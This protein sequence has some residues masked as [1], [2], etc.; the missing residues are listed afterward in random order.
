[1]KMS[2][3]VTIGGRRERLEWTIL[4]D[5]IVDGPGVSSAEVTLN[6]P[7]PEVVV[8]DFEDGY[9]VLTVSVLRGRL[10]ERKEPIYGNKEQLI[11]RLRGWDAKHPEGYVAEAEAEE[12]EDD[13]EDVVLDEEGSTVH[14][15]ED[16]DTGEV[17]EDESDGEGE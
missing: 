4:G 10:E 1:M 7:L 14:S 5:R 2:G 13:E 9:E 6:V 15:T 17:S 12:A 11:A 3:F 8:V 16:E